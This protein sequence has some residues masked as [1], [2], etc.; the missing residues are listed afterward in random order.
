MDERKGP[1]RKG[2]TDTA[3]VREEASATCCRGALSGA[4]GLVRNCSLG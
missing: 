1:E 3:A 4:K 2:A